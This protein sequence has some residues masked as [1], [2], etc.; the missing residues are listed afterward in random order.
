MPVGLKPAFRGPAQ[1]PSNFLKN[2]PGLGVKIPHLGGVGRKFNGPNFGVHL[3]R[4][5]NVRKRK[6]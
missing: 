6:K 1:L 5:K 2:I 4:G 3:G